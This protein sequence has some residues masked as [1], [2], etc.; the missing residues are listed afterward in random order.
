M[1][2]VELLKN[3]KDL[4][5]IKYYKYFI[6]LILLSLLTFKMEYFFVLI[7]RYPLSPLVLLLF[8]I[9]YLLIRISDIRSNTV[10]EEKIPEEQLSLPTNI[11]KEILFICKENRKD[12]VLL[13]EMNNFSDKD[14]FDIEGVV[15]IF[16]DKSTGFRDK[17]AE[18]TFNQ[19]QLEPKTSVQVSVLSQREFKEVYAWTSFEVELIKLRTS[20][21]I[22]NY[23]IHYCSEKIVR[24]Y[25]FILNLEKYIDKN[26]FFFR[27]P[28]NLAWL[29][30]NLSLMKDKISFLTSQHIFYYSLPK[31]DKNLTIVSKR[32]LSKKEKRDLRKDFIRKWFYKVVFVLLGSVS[33]IVLLYSM[34]QFMQL[35]LVILYDIG[36]YLL[37]RYL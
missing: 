18:K 19:K 11:E 35:I 25:D 12:D 6:L 10:L 30:E 15:K 9:V 3:L 1:N 32:K 27:I 13:L 24:S 37:K 28:Y 2:M 33:M 29:K 17:V 31:L 4:L 23:N 14:I 7:S 34:L 16:R 21:S 22:Q 36:K 20:D 26:I 5:P 8:I